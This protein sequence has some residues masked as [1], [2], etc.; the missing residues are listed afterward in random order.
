MIW[1]L[2]LILAQNLTQRQMGNKSGLFIFWRIC[3]E[4][5]CSFLALTKLFIVTT[6]IQVLRWPARGLVW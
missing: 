5:V 2:K 1:V 6:T 3:F 4:I